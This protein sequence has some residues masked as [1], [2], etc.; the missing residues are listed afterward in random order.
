MASMIVFLR[1]KKSSGA[2][3]GHVTIGGVG[4]ASVDHWPHNNLGGGCG[5]GAG[6]G[7]ANECGGGAGA[8]RRCGVPCFT[9]VD[10][11]DK[12]LL[13]VRLLLP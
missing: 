12:A 3:H 11:H 10:S 4:G 7:G 1:Q 8:D 6:G 9:S 13:L 5:T 2:G